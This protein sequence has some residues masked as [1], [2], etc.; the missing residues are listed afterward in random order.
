VKTSPGG[1]LYLERF[2]RLRRRRDRLRALAVLGSTLPK[3]RP[4]PPPATPP[5]KAAAGR[6]AW[7]GPAAAGA[8]WS[9]AHQ[10]FL[11]PVKRP[12]GYV[13]SVVFNAF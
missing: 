4:A 6:P 13:T 8:R 11:V 12:P 9:E 1:K 3:P 7:E 5:R 2:P 10:C